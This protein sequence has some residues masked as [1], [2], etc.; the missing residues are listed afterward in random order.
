M[1]VGSIVIVAANQAL[2]PTSPA[3]LPRILFYGA[4]IAAVYLTMKT[5]PKRIAALAGTAVFGLLVH[6][7]VGSVWSDGTSGQVTSGGFLGGVIKNW[8]CIPEHPSRLAVYGYLMLIV[9]VT[10]LVQLKG[11][12]RIAVL[13]PTLYLTAFVWE[14]L[15]I[16]QP[17]VT[18]QVL[19]G[20]MLIAVM[21]IRPQ[22]LFGQT[23][24]EIV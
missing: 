3:N 24:V 10:V 16:Q 17:S 8:S 18:R 5:W 20:L 7:I 22:G 2:D 19:L 11:W 6:A 14:N 1:I 4:V 15:M 12:W 23:K 21:T 9:S 13:V